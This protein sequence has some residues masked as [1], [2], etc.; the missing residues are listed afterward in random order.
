MDVVCLYAG[1]QGADCAQEIGGVCYTCP[2]GYP[3]NVFTN[4]ECFCGK[5]N[6]DQVACIRADGASATDSIGT[7]VTQVVTS[8]MA[9]TWVS[10]LV[11]LVL[12]VM[13]GHVVFM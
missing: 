13:V 9:T 4:G 12:G 11:V 10:F 8:G 7:G 3:N 1:V 5:D 2:E 6:G